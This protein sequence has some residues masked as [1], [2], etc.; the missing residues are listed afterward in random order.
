MTDDDKK[1]AAIATET[2]DAGPAFRDFT[3][4]PMR[5]PT[6]GGTA[7]VPAAA[8]VAA[9]GRAP[10]GA[11][12]G[13]AG[14]AAR[15]AGVVQNEAA[16]RMAAELMGNLGDIRDDFD[17]AA[18]AALV[19]R[20]RG[21]QPVAAPVDVP[22]R[23]DLGQGVPEPRPPGREVGPALDQLPAIPGLQDPR[24]LRVYDLPRYMHEGIRRFG[25]EIF[26]QY[27][28]FVEQEREAQRD[29]ED[30]LGMIRLVANINGNGPNRS[31]E[32]DAIAVWLRQN[33]TPVGAEQMD[34]GRTLPGYRPRVVQA[35]TRDHTFLL[36][37][38][39]IR[40]GAPTD[41]VYVYSWRGGEAY[42]NDAGLPL[43]GARRD[44]IAPAQRALPAPAGRDVPERAPGRVEVGNEVAF[45]DPRRASPPTVPAE[46]AASR[47]R[48]IAALP[49]ADV[50]RPAS[51]NPVVAALRSAGY[52]PM[53]C[54]EGPFLKRAV[55][56]GTAVHVF[57]ETG[58]PL[59][60]SAVFRVRILRDGE[61][62]R[63]D[64]A[65][66]AAEVMAL[67]EPSA[68]APRI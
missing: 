65:T 12:A 18:A 55:D 31:G 5:L 35:V 41:A 24:W 44:R 36:V 4:D 15:L 60:A 42:Y 6:A 37:E 67:V 9:P 28:C 50:V 38:E 22:L 8:P 3:V 68:A 43:P 29:G 1:T 59:A 49:Q 10:V 30:P 32:M 45:V 17:D 54:P 25:R 53:G 61:T 62:L 46:Q 26:R 33:G 40:E 64:T 52:T 19:A 47:R 66:S 39:R 34:F 14:A 7:R 20:R 23:D 56:D 11:D 57:G 13:A 2:Q 16:A 21:P 58:K 48:R 51:S 63:E 27:P